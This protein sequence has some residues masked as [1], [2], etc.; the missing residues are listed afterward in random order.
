MEFVMDITVSA[1]VMIHCAFRVATDQLRVLE[2][3]WRG[4]LVDAGQANFS[5][6]RAISESYT[7]AGALFCS[8][9]FLTF[10]RPPTS[11]SG[12]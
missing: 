8:S 3:E 11:T 6:R 1:A 10:R 2:N 4:E 9:T 7:V 12:R 5:V